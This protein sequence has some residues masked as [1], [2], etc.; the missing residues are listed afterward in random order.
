MATKDKKIGKQTVK[1]ENPPKI[2][3]TYSIVGPKEGDGPLRKYFHKII[4]KLMEVFMKK[5]FSVILTVVFILVYPYTVSAENKAP[6]VSAKACV[7]IEE[8]TGK[9]LFEKKLF[10]WLHLIDR[11]C[12]LAGLCKRNV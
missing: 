12:Q 9:I 7:L 2:I 10:R 5:I 11:R 4:K 6:E 8:K 3:S 1:L